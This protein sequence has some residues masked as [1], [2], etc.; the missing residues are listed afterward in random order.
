MNPK[1]SGAFKYQ[2]KFTPT[3]EIGFGLKFRHSCT[4]HRTDAS[5]FLTARDHRQFICTKL[6][7]CAI[8]RKSE[9]NTA[10]YPK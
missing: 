2:T 6:L 1:T 3:L 4:P 5:V 8:I 7:A 10:D 9:V